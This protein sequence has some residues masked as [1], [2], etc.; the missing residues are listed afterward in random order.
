MGH[1]MC[2]FIK[3]IWNNFL[4]VCD[5][6]GSGITAI[7][8]ILLCCVTGALGFFSW[9]AT[10]QTHSIIAE[11]DRQFD[12]TNRAYVSSDAIIPNFVSN[13]D[14]FSITLPYTN[15]GKTPADNVILKTYH[16][17]ASQGTT[18]MDGS[19]INNGSIILEPGATGNY[20]L[21]SNN[22]PWL[23]GGASNYGST[24]NYYVIEIDYTDFTGQKH[25]HFINYWLKFNQDGTGDIKTP[26][27]QESESEVN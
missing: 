17:T 12:I 2:G 6:H 15:Y 19:D 8:T 9:V 10:Q 20:V 22:P 18:S 13:S 3:T 23:T 5:K 1:Q 14:D 4:E 16:F 26:I 7:A 11:Q 27:Y 24:T 21:H 25:R